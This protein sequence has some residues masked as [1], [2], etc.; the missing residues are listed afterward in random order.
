LCCYQKK[1]SEIKGDDENEENQD[2]DNSVVCISKIG[3][4]QNQMVSVDEILKKQVELQAQNN[5]LINQNKMIQEKYREVSIRLT[6][7]KLVQRLATQKSAFKQ[8]CWVQKFC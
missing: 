7:R 5:H 4:V 3:S 6:K 1:D 2:V 8:S